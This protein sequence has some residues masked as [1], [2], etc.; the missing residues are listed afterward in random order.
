MS[1][2]GVMRVIRNGVGISIDALALPAGAGWWLPFSLWL[3]VSYQDDGGSWGCL[4]SHGGAVGPPS[5][6]D[7]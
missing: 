4:E 6:K 7:H 5:W 2:T 3:T 1:G